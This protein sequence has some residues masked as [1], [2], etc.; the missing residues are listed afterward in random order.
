MSNPFNRAPTEQERQMAEK[1]TS[2]CLFKTGLS[3]VAGFGLGAIFGLIMSSIDF[4]SPASNNPNATTKQQIKDTLRDMGTKSWASAKGFATVAAIYSGSE[5]IIE[6]Y[7]AKN[8]I[9]NSVSAGCVTG[10]IL[11]TKTGPK[12]MAF[13]CAGF[14]AFS[15]AID[16]YLTDR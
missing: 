16:I 3:G 7:R 6:S 2:S 4:S 15:A 8:D 9:Y 10:A 5:C 12:G 14:A 11:A 1:V 13:G